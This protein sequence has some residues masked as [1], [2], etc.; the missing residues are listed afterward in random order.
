MRHTRLPYAAIILAVFSISA[1]HSASPV[2]PS[3]TTASPAAPAGSTSTP[4]LSTSTGRVV[5]VLSGAPLLS[6]SL[7]LDE[8]SSSAVTGP[9]GAYRLSA[10]E[11]G[12]CL[13][14]INGPGMV[15]RQTTL[16]MPGADATLSLI[17]SRFDLGTFDQMYRGDGALHR[18]TSAPSL[19]VLDA[20]LQFTAETDSAF[21]AL[22]ER[23]T[24]EDIA[25]I[26]GDLEWGLVQATAGA[27]SA[28]ASVGVESPA[29]GT[30]VNLYSR[31]G[32]IVVARFRGL[33]LSSGHWGF[34]R[35]A[36]HGD[37]VA[38]G[39]VLLDRDFDAARTVY[40]RSLRVHELGHALGLCH[41]TSRTS[42]MN[43]SATVE[44]TDFDR[45][46]AMVAYQRAPGSQSPDRDASASRPTSLAARPS[47][48]PIVH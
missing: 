6:A 32:S 40:G 16:Q 5:D 38:A 21:T 17:P 46:A 41:V 28:F 15:T 8:G 26:Q 34:G 35:A 10:S 9:D 31:A 45:D 7:A 27:F 19:V 22:D 33:S 48:T 12:T 24:A 18:W 23:L 42:F 37:T 43:A 20:V 14:T 1:C 39:A 3:A 44:P 30:S 13:V 11:T 2:S 29:P 4:T 47:W 25:S 36:R